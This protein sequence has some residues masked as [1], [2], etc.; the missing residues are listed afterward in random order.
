MP[1]HSFVREAQFQLI[2]PIA[3][4]RISSPRNVIEKNRGP[5]EEQVWRLS[6]GNQGSSVESQLA[7]NFEDG[8]SRTRNAGV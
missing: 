8:E 6:L 7:T 4:N 2:S 3:F 5:F 1:L